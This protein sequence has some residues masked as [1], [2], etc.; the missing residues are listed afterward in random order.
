MIL[1]SGI[2]FWAKQRPSHSALVLG[3]LIHNFS[4]EQ[5]PSTTIGMGEFLRMVYLMLDYRIL[6]RLGRKSHQVFPPWSI[7]GVVLGC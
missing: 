3:R 5:A 6:G 4:S 7:L 2:A 1:E